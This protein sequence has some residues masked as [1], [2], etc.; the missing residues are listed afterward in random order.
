MPEKTRILI[1]DDSPRAR[2][3]L[4]ALLAIYAEDAE[5]QEAENG[6]DALERIDTSSPDVVLMDILMPEL[7]GLQATQ[8]IK[9]K[10]P[11]IKVIAMS[12]APD[13]RS[14][15]LAA[16]ADAFVCKGDSPGALFEAL[17][18]LTG[19]HGDDSGKQPSVL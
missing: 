7:D 15:A 17:A 2:N 11:Q 6:L 18:R 16:G 14:E 4:C 5:I 3:S 10:A 12:M 1:V 9:Q 8:F 19:L 13:Y